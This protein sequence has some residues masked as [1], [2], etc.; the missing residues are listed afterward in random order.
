MKLL[1]S[2]SAMIVLFSLNR[3]THTCWPK[4]TLSGFVLMIINHM[5]LFGTNQVCVF[6]SISGSKNIVGVFFLKRKVF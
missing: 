4:G 3:L 5:T 1:P 6:L 2:S